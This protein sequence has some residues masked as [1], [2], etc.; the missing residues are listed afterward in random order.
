MNLQT[1]DR[2]F[3]DSHNL[4]QPVDSQHSSCVMRARTRANMPALTSVRMRAAVS[5]GVEN[6]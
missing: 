4:K 3:P 6:Q 2:L 5:F 1:S